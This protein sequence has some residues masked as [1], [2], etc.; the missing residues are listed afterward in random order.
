MSY[1]S[2]FFRV[3]CGQ[4]KNMAEIVVSE[5]AECGILNVFG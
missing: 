2:V 1:A 5:S 4:N 3:F